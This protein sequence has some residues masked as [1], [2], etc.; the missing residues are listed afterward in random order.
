M[1]ATTALWLVLLIVALVVHGNRGLWLLVGA[2]FALF[3][4]LLWVWLYFVC[5]CSIYQ[6]E[7]DQSGCGEDWNRV[8]IEQR[9]PS[10]AKPVLSCSSTGGDCEVIALPG[11]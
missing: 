4:P 5:E 1:F 2:P 8:V 9:G 3:I 10:K 7:G 11:S 6:E